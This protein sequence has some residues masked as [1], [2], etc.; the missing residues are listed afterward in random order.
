MNATYTKGTGDFTPDATNEPT[1]EQKQRAVKEHAAA[2][3]IN[4]LQGYRSDLKTALM[5]LAMYGDSAAVF[6]VLAASAGDLLERGE[7]DG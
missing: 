2:A 7:I 6:D 4:A 1:D 3:V 5:E